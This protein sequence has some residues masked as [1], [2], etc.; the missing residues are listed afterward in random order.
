M[1]NRK[2]K[3]VF[4]FDIFKNLEIT[5]D[6]NSPVIRKNLNIPTKLISFNYAKTI[7]NSK[8][9]YVHFYIDDY[10]FE[11]IWNKPTKYINLLKKFAGIIGPDFSPYTDLSMCQRIW[12]TYRNKVLTAYW[13][14]L[15]LNVIPNARWFDDGNI[16]YNNGLDGL[17]QNSSLA[18]T[19][20]STQSPKQ[21]LIFKRELKDIITKL[22]P[23]NLIVYG[24]L[25]KPEKELCKQNNINVYEFKSHLNKLEEI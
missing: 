6:Y 20:N 4:N 5:G 2:Y 12:N 13:Q 7:K 21:Y 8:D 18:I 25:K 14:K 1:K 9:Y 17:P 11:R 24:M 10:Q 15:G 16:N 22:K 19:T 3:D 23:T